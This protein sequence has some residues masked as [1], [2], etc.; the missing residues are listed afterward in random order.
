MQSFTRPPTFPPTHKS[1][2]P[3]GWDIRGMKRKKKSA[4]PK[5][6]CAYRFPDRNVYVDKWVNCLFGSFP[7][8][9]YG[10]GG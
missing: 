6:N 1:Q 7:H 5:K 10:G 2:I 8:P 4:P 3:I 9:F